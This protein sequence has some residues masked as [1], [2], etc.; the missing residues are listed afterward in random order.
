MSLILIVVA[1]AVAAILGAAAYYAALCNLADCCG[2]LL[3]APPPAPEAEPV[4]RRGARP[5]RMTQMA[6]AR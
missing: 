5:A 4:A 2:P 6:A 1:A 3:G